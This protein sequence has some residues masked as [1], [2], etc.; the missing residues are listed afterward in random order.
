MRYLLHLDTCL[1]ILN[2]GDSGLARRLLATPPSE[3]AVSA[4]TAAALWEAA[5]RSPLREVA[6]ERVGAFLDEV[7]VQPFDGPAAREHARVRAQ[8]R[9]RGVV[10]PAGDAQVAAH[11][12]V[13]GCA[14]V[15]ERTALR[16][17]PGLRVAQWGAD[18]PAAAA[19]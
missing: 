3:V 17:I 5:E 9:E 16:R 7:A 1:D 4:V 2:R 19:R 10:L 12:L 18:D 14:L 8:L 6:V 13:L 11:A 15:S